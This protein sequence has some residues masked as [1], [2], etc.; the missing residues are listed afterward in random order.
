MRITLRPLQAITNAPACYDYRWM[1][2][3]VENVAID[4]KG[5]PCR[6][7][8][9]ED[10]WHFEQQ[11]LRYHSGMNLVITEQDRLDDFIRYG[12]LTLTED[13]VHIHRIKV[14]LEQAFDWERDRREAL[15]ENLL[16]W[17]KAPAISYTTGGRA[18]YYFTCRGDQAADEVQSQLASFGLTLESWGP[19]SKSPVSST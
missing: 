4:R 1:H 2:T 7:V 5:K 17:R 12:D 9:N 8:E 6:L 16:A 3:L 15:M 14:D 11:I 19:A 18:D 10:Q 13:P